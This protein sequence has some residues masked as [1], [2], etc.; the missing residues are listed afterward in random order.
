M[1]VDRYSSFAL[2]DATE[3]ERRRAMLALPHMSPLVSYVERGKAGRGIEYDVPLFDPCDGGVNSRI[4]FLLEA[5]GPKA[6]G[7]SSGVASTV[8]PRGVWSGVAP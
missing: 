8:R 6:V 4:L 2:K 3:I 5:P 1:T 7:S